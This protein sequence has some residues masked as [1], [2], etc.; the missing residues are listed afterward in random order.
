MAKLYPVFPTE[1]LLATK[2]DF[3]L[4][5]IVSPFVILGNFKN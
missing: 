5:N 2:Y 4:L 3:I 1:T